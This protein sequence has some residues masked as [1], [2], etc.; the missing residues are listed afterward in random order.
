MQSISVC[1][2][3]LIAL[4]AVSPAAMAQITHVKVTGGSIAL[5]ALEIRLSARAR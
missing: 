3:L 2:G 5:Q 1:S 4:A